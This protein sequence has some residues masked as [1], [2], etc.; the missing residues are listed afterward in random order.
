MVNTWQITNAIQQLQEDIPTNLLLNNNQ[1][2]HP[3]SF[4]LIS[5][6]SDFLTSATKQKKPTFLNMHGFFGYALLLIGT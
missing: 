1:A 6:M 2:P 3:A 5:L 4:S